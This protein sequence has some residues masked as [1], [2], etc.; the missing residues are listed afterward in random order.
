MKAKDIQIGARYAAKVSGQVQTV[1]I[2]SESPYGGCVARNTATGRE[3]RIKS[4][5]RLRHEMRDKPP[6]GYKMAADDKTLV[7]VPE[8][9]KAIA[10]MQELHA[11]GYSWQAIADELSRRGIPMKGEPR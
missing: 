5:Q 9:Q 1:K 2:L 8:E 4:P 6:F 7:A 11:A 3:V 10:L